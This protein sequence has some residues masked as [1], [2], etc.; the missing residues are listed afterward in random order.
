[1]AWRGEILGQIR[2]LNDVR[3]RLKQAFADR[4]EAV[5]LLTLALLCHEHLLLIGEPG[6]AKSQISEAFAAQVG[7]KPFHYL[8]TRFTEPSEIFGSVILK[9]LRKGEYR[10]NTTNMLPESSIAFLDEIFEGSSAILNTLLTLVNERV[11]FDG[12][13]KKFA[14]L[15]SLIGASNG[16]PDDP[17]LAAFS[18]RFL[19]R[20]VVNPVP[21][22]DLRQLLNLGMRNEEQRMKTFHERGRAV[23]EGNTALQLI[24]VSELADMHRMLPE[25]KLDPVLSL[26]EKVMRDLRRSQIAISDRRIVK[27]LKLVRGAAMLRETDHAS[28]ED[29]W[30]L[31]HIWAQ[32]EDR[33][34]LREVLS[35]SLGKEVQEPRLKKLTRDEAVLRLEALDASVE[36][37]NS[38]GSLWI[39]LEDLN[40]LRIEVRLYLSSDEQLLRRVDSTIARAMERYAQM[41]RLHV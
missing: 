7:T 29:F 19:L 6:T 23:A 2:R 18:D 5:D 11:Y 24:A 22:E 25:V 35:N 21:D 26:Y 27:G 38:Q 34:K 15:I 3:V 16:L 36:A 32:P 31:L 4:D 17:A 8:L 10:I 14:K 13:E 37:A 9:E 40:K 30:P 28:E 20:L 41:E 39:C 1:M 12:P 33:D